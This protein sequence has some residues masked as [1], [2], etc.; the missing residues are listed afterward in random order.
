MLVRFV[1]ANAMQSRH[2]TSFLMAVQ[3]ERGPTFCVQGHQCMVYVGPPTT[4]P[5]KPLS[6]NSYQYTAP[7]IAGSRGCGG[8]RQPKNKSQICDSC[9]VSTSQLQ[10][11]PIRTLDS[12]SCP[13]L[14]LFEEEKETASQDLTA[15]NRKRS[16][17]EKQP[18]FIFN[19][20]VRFRGQRLSKRGVKGRLWRQTW[21]TCE[22]Y[23]VSFMITKAHPKVEDKFS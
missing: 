17:V 13:I 23:F 5:I 9:H 15:R 4:L 3:C 12:D 1:S 14:R 16:G 22:N 8:A 20:K 10:S 19:N 6:C 21:Q 11:P 2:F 18:N 7:C